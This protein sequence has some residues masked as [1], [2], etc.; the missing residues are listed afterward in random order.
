MYHCV[1]RCVLNGVVAHEHKESFGKSSG[2]HK[3][4]LSMSAEP[5]IQVLLENQV[6]NRA[7]EHLFARSVTEHSVCE[8]K[9]LWPLQ[10]CTV[11]SILEPK[12]EICGI[13]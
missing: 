8:H 6:V 5:L 2:E 1:E 12:D 4:P 13:C 10:T 9:E 11:R 3:G 7:L